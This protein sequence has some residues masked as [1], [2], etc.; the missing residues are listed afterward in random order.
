MNKDDL[1]DK[2][3]EFISEQDRKNFDFMLR[4][5]KEDYQFYNLASYELKTE[6]RFINESI[7]SCLSKVNNEKRL[8]TG[9][10]ELRV[11]LSSVNKYSESIYKA[12]ITENSDGRTLVVR[13]VNRPKMKVRTMFH[14]V[15]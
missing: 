12:T 7:L 5:V 10:K 15:A 14:K 2:I 9:L 3:I 6:Y 13:D 8:S 4:K 11:F 1:N